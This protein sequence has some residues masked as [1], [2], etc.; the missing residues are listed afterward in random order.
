M[1]RP[2]SAELPGVSDGVVAVAV[3]SKR[4]WGVQVGAFSRY[5]PGASGGGQGAAEPAVPDQG[6]PDCRR[7][8]R[9]P[10]RQALSRPAGGPGAGRGERCLPRIARPA[11]PLPG[12]PGQYLRGDGPRPVRETSPLK[13]PADPISRWAQIPVTYISRRSNR[14][15]FAHAARFFTRP[16]RA[17]TRFIWLLEELGTPYALK[18][19]TIRRGDGSGALDPANPHPHGKVPVIIDGNTTVFKSPA[20]ALY[21]TDAYPKNRIGRCDRRSHPRR[22]S[23]MARLLRRC[24]GAGLHVEI[25]EYAGAARDRRLGPG[26]RGH[27]LHHQDA[28]CNIPICWAKAFRPPM[29]CSA[30]PSPVQHQPDAAQIA[31]ARRLCEALHR[32]PGLMPGPWHGTRAE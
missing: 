21:L 16:N 23:V 25:P 30:A 1:L 28:V 32:A 5:T 18:V 24:A 2:G 29:C 31:G 8:S 3:D 15:V 27:G 10:Q 20:I 17:R 11:D 19:V 7:R 26:R 6:Y 4:F 12:G 14:G 13:R 22:L 9:R